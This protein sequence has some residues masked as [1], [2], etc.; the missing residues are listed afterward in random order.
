MMFIT[1][2]DNR[3]S[4]FMTSVTCSFCASTQNYSCLANLSASNQS[5]TITL[6]TLA[7]ISRT[8]LG[9]VPLQICCKQKSHLSLLILA[10]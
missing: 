5:S 4:A 1:Y 7:A 2:W 3:F 8:L 9:S 6:G 10:Y